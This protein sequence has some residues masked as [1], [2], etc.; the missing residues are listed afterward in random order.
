MSILIC[1]ALLAVVIVATGL[2]AGIIWLV[3]K[4]VQTGM[5]L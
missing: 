1:I 3:I 4:A 2:V 5:F